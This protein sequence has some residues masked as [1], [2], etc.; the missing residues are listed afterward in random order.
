M[1]PSRTKRRRL[2][3]AFF[4][5]LALAALLLWQEYSHW[6]AVNGPAVSDPT[7]GVTVQF[8]DVDQ[9]ES[10]LLLS[11]EDAI[12]IDGGE[13]A[14][15]GK[16]LAALRRNGV[17][18]LSAMVLT[19]PHSDHYGGLASV[20][21][22]LPVEG[23]YTPD[24]PESLLPTTLSYQTLWETLEAEAVPCYSTQVGMT[25]S[26]GEAT[27][28]VL[29]PAADAAFEDLNDYSAVLRLDYG[30]VSFLF[31]GDA[32]AAAEEALL[33]SGAD[34]DVTV[35]NVGHHGSNSSST[36]E[37]LRAV[38]PEYAV[39]SVGADNTYNLP[40]EAALSRLKAAGTEIYRTDRQGTV[41]VTTDGKTVSVTTAN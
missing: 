25:L 29:A 8:L 10:I 13:S 5:L 22:Y 16:V 18:R 3:M 7:A 21:E 38:S 26:L 32:E 24:I 9:A 30:E 6:Q 36:E 14:A 34:L 39:I 15:G 35:L 19:H 33:K 11:G 20:L 23:F 1:H 40:G 2:W 41:T 37:F 27:L 12:L 31:T 4:A 17:R 28:T